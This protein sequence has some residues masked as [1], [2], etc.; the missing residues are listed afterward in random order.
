M[1]IVPKAAQNV[2]GEAVAVSHE[3]HE[4]DE[5]GGGKRCYRVRV[6][7]ELLSHLCRFIRHPRN[8]LA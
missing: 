7:R 8:L 6:N 3:K 1:I 5:L 2:P 4:P